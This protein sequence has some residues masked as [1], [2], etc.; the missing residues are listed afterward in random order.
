MEDDFVK[1]VTLKNDAPEMVVYVNFRYSSPEWM[2][3]LVLKGDTNIVV[4]GITVEMFGQVKAIR[5][6]EPT[7]TGGALVG[8][9]QAALNGK[10]Y[11]KINDDLFKYI[12]SLFWNNPQIWRDVEAYSQISQA[13]IRNESDINAWKK[14]VHK[15]ALTH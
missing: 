6:Q 2:D 15:Y 9:I 13:E 11:A 8:T 12:S 14:S 5:P 4:K 3:E 10:K 1:L 7:Q